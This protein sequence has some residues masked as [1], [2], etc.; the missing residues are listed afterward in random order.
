MKPNA[1]KHCLAVLMYEIG[2]QVWLT[3]KKLCLT[4]TSWKHSKRWLGPYTIIGLASSNAIKLQLLRSLQIHPVVNVSQVK[5]YHKPMK[6]QTLYQLGPVYTTKDRDNEWEVDYIVDSHL[7]RRKLE[8]LIHW[9]GYDGSD[10]TWK[11]KSNLRNA[12]Y[13]ICDFYQSYSSTTCAISI[14]LVDFLLLFQKQ[15][16]PFTEVY[17]CCLPFDCLEVN[18]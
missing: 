4:H 13:A 17:S 7:K 1:D 11:F 6:E 8:Y 9:K 2:Q 5:L 16:E 18:L 15:P 14:D 3:T 12:K 10:H